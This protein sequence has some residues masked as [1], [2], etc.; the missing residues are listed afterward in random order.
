MGYT[1]RRQTKQKQSRE[2]GNIGYTRRR[3]TKQKQSRETGNIGYTR[4]R[5][6]KQKQS[7]EAGNIGYTRRRQTKQK[8]KTICAI[9]KQTYKHVNKLDLLQKSGGKDEPNIVFMRKS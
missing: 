7:R 2:T 6:T 3:K 9:H 5:K 8:H 4:R 1:R